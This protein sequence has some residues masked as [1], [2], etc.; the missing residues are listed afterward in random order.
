MNKHVVIITLRNNIIILH[1]DLCAR[2]IKYMQEFTF[3]T[4][5]ITPSL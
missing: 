4:I 3:G 1:Y 5:A 2:H